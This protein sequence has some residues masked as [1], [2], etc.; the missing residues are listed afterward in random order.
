MVEKVN[1]FL[2]TVLPNTFELMKAQLRMSPNME[3]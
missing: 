1:E 3:A 2:K